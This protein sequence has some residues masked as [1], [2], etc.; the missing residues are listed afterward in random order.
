MESGAIAKHTSF[1]D[2]IGVLADEKYRDASG[3]SPWWVLDGATVSR[4][5]FDLPQSRDQEKFN[6]LKE[7]RLIYRLA[8]GQPNQEDLVDFLAKGGPGLTRIL[9]NPW[10]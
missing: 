2:R 4:F 6:L 8:L 1:W 5:V 7:Q 3:L 10:L 9:D